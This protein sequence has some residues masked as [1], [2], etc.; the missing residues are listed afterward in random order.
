M[1]DVLGCGAWL[2]LQVLGPSYSA[3]DGRVD[4]SAPGTPQGRGLDL[5]GLADFAIQLSREI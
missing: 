5:L 3:P 2:R 1:V 4:V